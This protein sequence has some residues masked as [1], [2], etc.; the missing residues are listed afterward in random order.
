MREMDLNLQQLVVSISRT[1][2]RQLDKVAE[3]RG[4]TVSDVVR[5]ALASAVGTVR[6]SKQDYKEIARDIER[7]RQ[8]RLEIR[9]DRKRGVKRPNGRPPGS[10][11]PGGHGKA[12]RQQTG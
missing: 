2:R 9:E 1:L 7:A 6:L 5:A 12:K 3:E 8:T 10:Q 11:V 4:G